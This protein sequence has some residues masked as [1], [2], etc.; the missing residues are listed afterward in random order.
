M[1]LDIMFC[2]DIALLF[3]YN[4]VKKFTLEASLCRF[5]QMQ[6]KSIVL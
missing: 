5:W 4:N 2:I 6:L 1:W 3:F